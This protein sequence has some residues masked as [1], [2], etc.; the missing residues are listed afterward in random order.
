[1]IKQSILLIAVLS[2]GI[3]VMQPQNTHAA[4][5]TI[6]NT[7]RIVPTCGIGTPVG[8]SFSDTGSDDVTN[9]LELQITN[10]GNGNLS[11]NIFATDWVDT[12]DNTIIAIYG[13]N[14]GFSDTTSTFSSKTLLNATN[15]PTGISFVDI[16]S[17]VTNSTWWQVDTTLAQGSETYTGD[18][19]QIITLI[20]SCTKVV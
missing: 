11:L 4:D 9:E 3:G 5:Q 13:N 8:V 2:I 7:L 16:A 15:E 20:A 6:E 19:K 14:T 10:S 12:T 18:I 17:G 1:M